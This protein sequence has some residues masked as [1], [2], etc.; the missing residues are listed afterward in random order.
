M[1]AQVR[2]SMAGRSRGRVALCAICTVD[3]EMRSAGFLVE[4]QNQGRRY[5]SGLASKPLGRFSPVWPQN[6][7]QRFLIGW[8]SKLMATLCEWF[9]IK[10][11]RT[12][13][14]GL[15]SKPMVTVSSVWPQNMLRRFLAVWP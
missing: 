13:F 6:R 2:Y 8:A 4:P 15:A 7:W 1:V 3:V 12:V 10:T 11:T 14:T 5:V 9:G